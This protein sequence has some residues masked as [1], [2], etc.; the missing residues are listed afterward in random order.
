MRRTF[1]YYSPIIDGHEPYPG[2]TSRQLHEWAVL[3]THDGHT[4]FYKHLRSV[5]QI[6]D[7]LE[8]LEMQDIHVSRGG[9]GV[10]ARATA[11]MH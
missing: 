11:P 3:D 6:R 5:E 2:L 9:N 7:C 4:D 1:L 8:S 10:E